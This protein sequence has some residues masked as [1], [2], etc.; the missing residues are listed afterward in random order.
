MGLFRVVLLLTNAAL[1]TPLAYLVVKDTGS[2]KWF[3]YALLACLAA[4]FVFLLLNPQR[5]QSR[6]FRV[7][8]LWFDAKEAEL[9]ARV[10]KSQRN[11]N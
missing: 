8:S 5:M 2:A 7:L 10:Q 1:F 4:N 11:S 3:G 6:V 9:R